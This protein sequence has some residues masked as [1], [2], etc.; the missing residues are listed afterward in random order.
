MGNWNGRTEECM[1]A[2]RQQ[3]FTKE[4][5]RFDRLA[6]Q[7][8]PA[9]RV[10]RLL[11]WLTGLSQSSNSNRITRL[12]V[13]ILVL[14]MLGMVPAPRTTAMAHAQPELLAMAAQH[15][16]SRVN[17]I[18][19]KAPHAFGVEDL[20]TRLGGTVT[21][22]LHIIN[23]FA[24]DVPGSA[25]PT[26]ARAENVRWTSLDAPTKQSATTGQFISWATTPGTSK[27]T[28]F[29]S[30]GSMIDSPFGP[31]QTF[32]SGDLVQG[33]FA[34]FR[35]EATPGTK[36]SKVQLVVVGYAP[37]KLIGSDDPIV[38]VSVSG[39]SSKGKTLDGTQFNSFISPTTE[40]AVVLDI[41]DQHTWKWSDF[42]NGLEVQLDQSKFVRGHPLYYDALGLLVTSATGTDTTGFKVPT[43]LPAA[44]LS[45]ANLANVY[46]RVVR[47]TD[48]WNQS[49]KYL[50]GQ[51]LTVAV[52]DSGFQNNKDIDKRLLGNANFN[53][54]YHDSND[55]YGHGSFVA[56]IVADD[57]TDSKGMRIGIAPKTNVINVRVSDDEGMASEADV[58]SALQW[59][60]DNR[61]SSNI[62]V[63]NLSLNSAVAQSCDV[64]PLCAAVEILWFN[65]IVVVVSAGN[66]GNSTL[67]PPANDPFAITVG[68]TN[69]LG[70]VSMSDDVVAP[71]S[72][73]GTTQNSAVKPDLVAP[74]TN[75]IGY[76][77]GNDK[78]TVG[79]Q[80]AS[81]RLD[82]NYFRMSGTSMAAPIVS[83][84]VAM[85]L[86]DEPTLTPDQVK[87]RLMATAVKSTAT[88]PGYDAT[89]A[90]A[91]YLDISA[92]VNG[93][94]TASANTGVVQSKLLWQNGTPATWGSA[95][96]GSASWGSASWGSAS[97]GSASWGSDYWGQ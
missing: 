53:A 71:Y 93:T 94:T 74:G 34:G 28:T 32:G 20:V 23:A 11:R 67:Y 66:N 64:D 54:A 65:K 62:R 47:A 16:S 13:A 46:N 89:R 4:T 26:L 44:P 37:I 8:Q 35:A 50:Q 6:R 69:D 90:G 49:P 12:L 78:L 30:A 18:V 61:T 76:L 3:R 82:N 25:V 14:P 43:S 56:G 68:A 7:A 17:V 15:P 27:T 88:W 55:R 72:A 84:A 33:A 19:Q 31:N 2:A 75:I 36:I 10:Q 87:Y 70:T 24:A 96:W 85:L 83:G 21:K 42:D 73:Y 39:V 41:T 58:V 51:G 29:A 79:K 22:D 40:N 63:V 81:N 57:G 80:H 97:W 77:P 95:S 9:T 38:K 86:Q 91:G 92:A 5:A 48:V 45:T 60:N 59:V 1:L 52:V